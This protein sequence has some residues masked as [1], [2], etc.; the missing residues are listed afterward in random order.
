MRKI[1]IAAL[2]MLAASTALWSTAEA[3]TY[4]SVSASSG[5]HHRQHHRRRHTA[6]MGMTGMSYHLGGTRW[7]GWSSNPNRVEVVVDVNGGDK[8]YYFDNLGIA[9]SW[10]YD[11]YGPDYKIVSV[12]TWNNGR[13]ADATTSFY[14]W[15]TDGSNPVTYHVFPTR[16]A[17]QAWSDRHSGWTVGTWDD[18]HGQFED[19]RSNNWK[20]WRDNHN[21]GH[22]SYRRH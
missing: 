19:W 6:V 22:R 10:L 13:K 18:M 11:K 8:T 14:V 4:V 1:L 21:K 17:A 9:H 16:E 2:L 5:A 15:R 20:T 12:N 3:K 7:S